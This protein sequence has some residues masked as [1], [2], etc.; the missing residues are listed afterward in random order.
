MYYEIYAD[1]LFLINFVMNLYL[2]IL[3]NRSLFCTATHSR[4]VLGAVSGAMGSLLPFVIPGIDLWRTVIIGLAGT[5]AMLW[6]TFRPKTLQAFV[7]TGVRLFLYSLLLGGGLLLIYKFILP[8]GDGILHLAGVLAGETILFGGIFMLLRRLRK[9]QDICRATLVQKGASITVTAL[10]DS[11][12]SLYEPVSGKP[13]C[14]IDRAV[15]ESLWKQKEQLFR[16]IPYHSIGRKHGILQGYVLPELRVEIGGIEKCFRQVYVA[17][18]EEQISVCNEN[19]RCKVKM[20]LHPALLQE[21][22]S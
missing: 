15:F 16:A 19:V 1:S 17:V 21:R 10:V 11:G 5:A 7:D 22:V 3:V 8:F 20:L 4:L 14:I 2:L 9:R 12:N 18:C 13:V 6:V